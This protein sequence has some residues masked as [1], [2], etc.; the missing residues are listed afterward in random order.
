MT[1]SFSAPVLSAFFF[2][3]P[4]GMTVLIFPFPPSSS[5]P[6]FFSLFLSSAFKQHRR[7]LSAPAT[8][9]HRHGADARW[10]WG[11]RGGNASRQQLTTVATCIYDGC[12]CRRRRKWAPS[13]AADATTTT[14]QRRSSGSI[15]SGGTPSAAAAVSASTTVV[16]Q[17]GSARAS[18]VFARACACRR[19]AAALRRLWRRR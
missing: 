17:S 6:L 7:R 10:R 2:L 15:G 8:H 19:M 14:G 3:P 18:K 16:S 12:C 9:Y 1:V 11:R 4:L 5:S 13:T